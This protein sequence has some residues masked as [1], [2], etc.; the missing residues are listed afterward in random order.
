[1]KSLTQSQT[2]NKGWHRYLSPTTWLL[3]NLFFPALCSHGTAYCTSLLLHPPQ[4]QLGSALSAFSSVLPALGRS[5][6]RITVNTRQPDRCCL[7][8]TTIPL[9][10]AYGVSYTHQL[11]PVTQCVHN[12]L[13]D[14]PSSHTHLHPTRTC[15]L[16]HSG[17]ALQT[18]SHEDNCLSI[19]VLKAR[20]VKWL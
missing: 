12:H 8:G 18:E 5:T 14:H 1:M 13:L 16:K 11:Q 15:V 4:A 19:C 7:S 10:S 2:A 17:Q 9:L 3:Q 6:W 20:R